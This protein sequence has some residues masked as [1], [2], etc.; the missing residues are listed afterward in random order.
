MG[1]DTSVDLSRSLSSLLD[2]LHTHTLVRTCR[3]RRAWE[4]ERERAKRPSSSSRFSL[5]IGRFD[6]PPR[7]VSRPVSQSV[8]P[9]GPFA[10]VARPA[11]GPW[12]RPDPLHLARIVVV[13]ST[14]ALPFP[15]LIPR[16]MGR[17]RVLRCALFPPLPPCC[18]CPHVQPPYP[19]S[20]LARFLLALPTCHA[21]MHACS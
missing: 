4:G 7:A 6:R 12:R 2:Q 10:L 20:L 19:P 13:N 5:W 18:P 3:P 17:V 8:N 15:L 9:L 11:I 21:C 1:V 14:A 16:S